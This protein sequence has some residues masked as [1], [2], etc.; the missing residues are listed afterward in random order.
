MFQVWDMSLF[1]LNYSGAKAAAVF[2]GLKIS[3]QTPFTPFGRAR[4]GQNELM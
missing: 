1:N 2:P 4:P 3:P